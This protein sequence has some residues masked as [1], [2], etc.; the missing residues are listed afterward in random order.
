MDLIEKSKAHFAAIIDKRVDDI[1]SF[2]A[3]TPELQ[4][5]VEGPRWVT[6][7]YDNVAKGWRDF[8]ASDISMLECDWVEALYSK[9]VGKMGFVG[10]IVELRVSIK[11]ALK[12]IRFRGSFVF[13]EVADGD[14][15]VVHEHFSQPAGDPYGIGDWLK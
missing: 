11:G 13:E 10:G 7:G 1:L 8:C 9:V 14:W 15:R 6:I 2:Y 5:F 4:V 3:Q 12:T